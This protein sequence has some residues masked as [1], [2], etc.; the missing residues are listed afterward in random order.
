MRF[1]L[2]LDGT[3]TSAVKVYQLDNHPRNLPVAQRLRE[4]IGEDHG[5]NFH[6]LFVITN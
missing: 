1:L 2:L 6:L 5:Y 4:L 3:T